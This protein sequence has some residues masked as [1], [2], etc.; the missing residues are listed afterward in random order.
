MRIKEELIGILG[1]GQLALY[2]ALKCISR[3][4]KYVVFYENNDSIIA[5]NDI[6]HSIK[7]H[8]DYRLRRNQIEK[9]SV[10]I[11]ENENYSP[12]YLASINCRFIPDLKSY[13][14]FHEKLNQKK[15]FKECLV[16][17]IKFNEISD[18]SQI[19]SVNQFPVIAKKNYYPHQHDNNIMC[20]DQIELQKYSA[21]IGLPLLIEEKAE[22]QREFCI[23]IVKN[24]HTIIKYPILETH[25]DNYFLKS[26]NSNFSLEQS[27]RDQI[28]HYTNIITNKLGHG[29][30]LLKFYLCTNNQL[31]LNEGA[32][33]PHNSLH[34]TEDLFNI[35]QYDYLL[36]LA[37]NRELRPFKKI[38]NQG[39]YL[40]IL[41]DINNEMLTNFSNQEEQRLSIKK[42][43]YGKRTK[44]KGQK[45]GHINI[46]S[47][48]LAQ[49][50]IDHFIAN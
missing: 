24:N 44:R 25:S 1:E 32:A 29:L 28:D 17:L 12:L 19:D 2:L 7:L 3:K 36:D 9:C 45:I 23:G 47:N 31:Y 26:V 48:N 30:F 40:S 39:I 42:Y 38:Q 14:I 18:V 11:L 33:R 5:N 27:V 21:I 50:S 35:S 15:F 4:I 20:H 41:N 37:M 49:D 13:K 46:L 8:S 34:L 43:H 22:I 16:P 10:V 6:I